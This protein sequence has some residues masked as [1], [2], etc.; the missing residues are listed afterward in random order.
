[1]LHIVINPRFSK[2]KI[3]VID[4]ILTTILNQEY[5]I[6]FDDNV[7]N[8]EIHIP[9]GNVLIVEDH[10]FGRIQETY[11][12]AEYIP[13]K[14]DFAV[15][16][17]FPERDIPVIYGRSVV[18][19]EKKV[20]DGIITSGI[21][22]FSS[23]FFM[24]SR[25]EEY[26]SSKKD[27]HQRFLATSSVALQFKFL[28]RPVVNEYAEFL[29]NTLKALGYKKERVAKGAEF[30][31]THD[32]DFF[33]FPRFSLF[34]A[35]NAIAK[36]E[37]L[38]EQLV[39]LKYT[40]RKD[41]YFTYK[42]LMDLSEANNVKAR[43]Y[44]VTGRDCYDVQQYLTHCRFQKI[45]QE[46]RRRGHIVGLHPGYYSFDDDE[47]MQSEKQLIEK[48]VEGAVSEGRQHYLRFHIPQT[49]RILNNQ[50]MEVDST[51][52]YPDQAGFRCG[53][54]QEF[55]VFDVL[56]RR[57]LVLKERPLIAMDTTLVKYNKFSPPQMATQLD[58]LISKVKKYHGQF[59][60][61]WHNTAIEQG[62]WKKYKHVFEN[63]YSK[64]S[65]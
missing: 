3:Y 57:K 23:A 58:L 51:L 33:S 36:P 18:S 53:I 61:L 6:T 15:S 16:D 17:Y 13:Q 59:V 54:C 63:L 65:V 7:A 28:D 49:W 27:H 48:H 46:I 64:F 2:E 41:P 43:F 55:P 21:D 29:W 20:S 24:L 47:A 30:I 32:I 10:F 11:L 38:K 9:N 12:S 40:F 60:L 62:E 22:I 25:W 37:A 56:A 8:Y 19:D 35:I 42:Y 45:I 39:R 4:I 52:G 50:G 14:V 34:S 5:Q 31:P 1:M 26:V 44:F